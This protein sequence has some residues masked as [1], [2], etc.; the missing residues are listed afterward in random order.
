M[1]SRFL[2]GKDQDTL[3]A[4]ELQWRMEYAKAKR[5]FLHSRPAKK[6][7]GRPVKGQLKLSS[8][9]HGKLLDL[10]SMARKVATTRTGLRTH[11]RAMQRVMKT[12]ETD[13]LDGEVCCFS[14]LVAYAFN[15]LFLVFFCVFIH[16]F[17]LL[18][19]CYLLVCTYLLIDYCLYIC[20]ISLIMLYY[21]AVVA[22]YCL[23]LA[24]LHHSDAHTKSGTAMDT[25]KKKW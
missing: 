6:Q 17:Y 23:L 2:A 19:T 5:K 4:M 8:L 25:A 18:T 11:K 14:L 22:I 10:S 15:V 20:F 7:Q 3:L 1:F 9:D 24:L 12:G 21:L 16:T 13:S